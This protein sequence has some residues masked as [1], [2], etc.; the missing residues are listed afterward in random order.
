MRYGYLRVQVVAVAVVDVAGG[1]VGLRA[2]F[3]AGV[4]GRVGQVAQAAGRFVVLGEVVEV[5]AQLHEA[6]KDAEVALQEFL[7][8]LHLYGVLGVQD[9]LHQQLLAEGAGIA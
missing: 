4:R 9:E 5:K 6:L 3:L 2:Y 8:R 7:Q 1:E